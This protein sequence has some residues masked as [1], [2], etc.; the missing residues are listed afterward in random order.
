MLSV[1]LMTSEEGSEAGKCFKLIRKT[2]FAPKLRHLL[3]NVKNKLWMYCS[4]QGA[5]GALATI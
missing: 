3:Q 1:R 4:R 5:D 2:L